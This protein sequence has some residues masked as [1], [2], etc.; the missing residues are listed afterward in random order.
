M[1]KLNTSTMTSEHAHSALRNTYS[2][3][4]INKRKNYN[5][6]DGQK[7]HTKSNISYNGASPNSSFHKG[8]KRSDSHHLISKITDFYDKKQISDA[9]LSIKNV[10]G[11][12]KFLDSIVQR[13]SEIEEVENNLKLERVTPMVLKV[14]ARIKKQVLTKSLGSRFMKSP[15]QL[16]PLN[17]KN[18][19]RDSRLSSCSGSEDNTSRMSWRYDDERANA[20]SSI[21]KDAAPRSLFSKP[22]ADNLPASISSGGEHLS[23]VKFHP[24]TVENENVADVESSL[25]T[26]KIRKTSK[27]LAL[28]TRNIVQK[29]LSPKGLVFKD[30][31]ARKQSNDSRGIDTVNMNEKDKSLVNRNK[32]MSLRNGD[33][34]LGVKSLEKDLYRFLVKNENVENVKEVITGLEEPKEPIMKDI[35]QKA[36]TKFLSFMNQ[37]RQ[38]NNM[39][40]NSFIAKTN[41]AERTKFIMGTCKCNSHQTKSKLGKETNNKEDKKRGSHVQSSSFVRSVNIQDLTRKDSVA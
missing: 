3:F 9:I 21:L 30:D 8:L 16:D 33:Y 23:P 4:R 27:I 37:R 18:I 15:S 6:I 40:P 20:N 14:T 38:I 19:G 36:K 2:Q 29:A 39:L 17:I 32:S 7:D 34:H 11:R 10:D 28:L 26:E 5:S 1:D 13:R 24:Y 41:V 12:K 35:E 31:E 25:R 22:V